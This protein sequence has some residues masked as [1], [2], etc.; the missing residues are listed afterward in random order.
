MAR[1]LSN[2]IEGYMHYTR[3][4]ESP[5]SFHYWTAVSTIAGALRRQVWIDEAYFEWTPNFYIILVGPPGVAAKSTSIQQGMK[6]LKQVPKVTMGPSSVTW[7]KLVMALNEAVMMVPL[8]DD[9]SEK[10]PI[11]CLTCPVRELGTFLRPQDGE[12]L[13]ILVD[14]WDAQRGTWDRQTKTQGSTRIENPWLNI[15]GC[16]TP[17]WLRDNFPEVMIGGGLASRIIFVYGD[18]KRD[19]VAY[20]SQQSRESLE[21]EERVLLEDLIEIGKLRGEFKLTEEAIEWG[22]E[23]YKEHWRYIPQHMADERYGG[24]RARKQTHIHKLAMVIAASKRQGLTITLEDLQEAEKNIVKIEADMIRVFE[25][26]GLKDSS[27]FI[28]HITTLLIH[29]GET[30]AK[31]LWRA[32]INNMSYDDFVDALGAAMEA[33]YIKRQQDANNKWLYKATIRE[34]P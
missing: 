17:A 23:W 32:C 22:S 9:P 6:F 24:Y 26:I 13:D 8:G 19:L 10:T 34:L 1:S 18:K 33:G 2:W 12:M 25:S 29:W 31:E 15:I 30:P 27:K 5:D 28:R 14:L 21:A 4:S 3:Y 20:P 7:P 11:S 16:T